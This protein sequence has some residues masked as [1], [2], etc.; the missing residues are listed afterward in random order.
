MHT[1]NGALENQRQED[2]EFEASLGYKSPC[3]KNHFFKDVKIF[4][5]FRRIKY[6]ML[7]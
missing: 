7:N 1:S 5:L 6:Y 4:V 2:Q 3:L